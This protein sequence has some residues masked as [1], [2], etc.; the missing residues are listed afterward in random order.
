MTNPTLI[1][2]ID[3]RA[4]DFMQQLDS[5][6][7]FEMEEDLLHTNQVRSLIEQ[8]RGGVGQQ[9]LD[10]ADAGVHQVAIA[11]EDGGHGFVTAGG[12]P[13]PLSR[14][15]VLPDV[16][17]VHRNSPAAET[18]AQ[19]HAERASRAPVELER[20]RVCGAHRNAACPVRARPMESRCISEVPS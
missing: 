6:L 16:H 3:S 8:V 9:G 2:R 11:D 4:T 20:G 14:R 13:N 10:L 7:G 17:R 12:L 1:T 18:M 15:W 5:R 19:C